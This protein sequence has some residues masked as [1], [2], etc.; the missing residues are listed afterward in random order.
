MP[1]PGGAELDTAQIASKIHLDV[2]GD[3]SK[4]KFSGAEARTTITERLQSDREKLLQLP[5]HEEGMDM[6][7]IHT[8]RERIGLPQ[9]PIR[10]LS[11]EDYAKALEITEKEEGTESGKY[12]PQQDVIIVKRDPESETINGGP[13]VTES[14]VVHEIAH[15]GNER[16]VIVTVKPTRRLIRK[17]K[18]YITSDTGRSGFMATKNG[19][20]SGYLLEEGYAEL[21]RGK[22]VVEELGKPE[23]FAG[24]FVQD[25]PTP[26]DKYTY[27]NKDDEGKVTSSIPNGAPAAAM[28]EL[29]AE[30]DPEFLSA[31]REGRRSV[32]GLREVARRLNAISPTLY[33]ELRR[34]DI[35]EQEG[36]IE[37]INMNKKVK[38]ILEA[39]K[40]T[41]QAQPAIEHNNSS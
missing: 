33:M 14:L 38:D 8:Y 37:A 5:S 36:R 28:F 11:P 19:E 12:L 13:E 39:R 2:K 16:S 23:G 18:T 24:R 40:A 41:S 20:P 3:L 15:S 7:R 10:V 4:V 29:I 1:E 17:N 6:A 22:Y 21:E 9:K 31:L 35:R 32:Q 30:Y 25:T 34:I 27:N 26:F